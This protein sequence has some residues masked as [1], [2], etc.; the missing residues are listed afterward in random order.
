MLVLLSPAGILPPATSGASAAYAISHSSPHASAFLLP[1]PLLPVLPGP[2][3]SDPLGS[4]SVE[5]GPCP[6][7]EAPTP[8]LFI[9]FPL[10]P[11][12][13]HHHAVKVMPS[14]L[15]LD[16]SC[17]C[18]QSPVVLRGSAEDVWAES[19]RSAAAARPPPCAAAALPTPFTYPLGFLPRQCN[20]C[21]PRRP[22]NHCHACR[23]PAD[24]PRGQKVTFCCASHPAS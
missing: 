20:H 13:Q 9:F 7:P 21:P 2:G 12:G 14:A 11:Q 1:V 22:G 15:G 8:K 17:P 3:R 5:V 18:S 4:S 23:Q 6:L 24:I 16:R 10:G 19:R